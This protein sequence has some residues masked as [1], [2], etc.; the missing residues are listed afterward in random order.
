MKKLILAFLAT[1]SLTML[2]ME[3]KHVTF[4]LTL[5]VTINNSQRTL[6]Q[7]EIQQ[8]SGQNN[9]KKPLINKPETK[10]KKRLNQHQQRITQPRK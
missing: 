1:G 6:S 2:A 4:L 5:A 8:F 3:H 9:N 10:S 7:K